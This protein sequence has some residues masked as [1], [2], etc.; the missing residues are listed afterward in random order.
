MRKKNSWNFK[1][2]NPFEMRKFSSF[3]SQK[4]LSYLSLLSDLKWPYWKANSAHN[5]DDRSVSPAQRKKEDKE[6]IK[7]QECGD[8]G[9][10]KE[11]FINHTSW[12]KWSEG[13]S[14]GEV[15]NLFFLFVPLKYDNHSFFQHPFKYQDYGDIYAE[16]KGWNIWFERIFRF[17][18]LY[19]YCLPVLMTNILLFLGK[20]KGHFLFHFKI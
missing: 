1:Q 12:R 9:V 10:T 14:Y 11:E 18:N 17:H 19:V 16:C 2:S 7:Q 15:E 6:K 3:F 20:E 5:P 4:V 13:W 8:L